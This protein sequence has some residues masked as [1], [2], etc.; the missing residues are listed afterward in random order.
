[1]PVIL[2]LGVDIATAMSPS[3]DNAQSAGTAL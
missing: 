1:M 2:I 3:S